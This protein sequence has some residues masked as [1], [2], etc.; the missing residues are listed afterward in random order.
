MRLGALALALLAPLSAQAA[1]RQALALGLD[2]SGSVDGAEY[3]Q[4]LDGLALAL[5][6]PDVAAL[7]V[8]PAAAPVRLMVYEWSGPD[9]Q[10]VLVPWTEIGTAEDLAGIGQRLLDT[11]RSPAP[12]TTA[13]GTALAFGLAQLDNQGECWR[14][15]LD[16]SGDGQSNAGPRPQDLGRASL[17]AGAVVNGLVIGDGDGAGP[18]P[19]AAAAPTIQL[20]IS[21]QGGAAGPGAAGGP[22]ATLPLR[23]YYEAYVIRGE[24]AFVETASSFDQY[25][26]AMTRKLIREL[27]ALA[28]GTGP[29]GRPRSVDVADLVDPVALDAPQRR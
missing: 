20:P 4:Q 28:I 26:A 24:D 12:P 19:G 22:D 7:L 17:P 1:C 29:D 18:E 21:P 6:A 23:S 9:F 27:N 16:L 14:R 13:L 2:V 11:A 15:T 10:R 5:N 8:Q 25:A 3:R